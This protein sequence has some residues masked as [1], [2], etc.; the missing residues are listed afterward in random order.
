MLS[1]DSSSD[2][3]SQWKDIPD[4][5]LCPPEAEEDKDGDG[6]ASGGA[7]AEKAS[8]QAGNDSGGTGDEPAGQVVT[9]EVP[10]SRMVLS[11]LSVVVRTREVEESRQLELQALRGVATATQA[12]MD[13]VHLALANHQWVC[14]LDR[15]FTLLH[16]KLGEFFF[17]NTNVG[18]CDEGCFRCC[19]VHW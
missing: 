17:F 16:S 1:S 12:L 5:A 13:S 3:P 15:T 11:D 6:P 9:D 14:S 7:A 18:N 10:T 2:A 4:I 8:E 19:G